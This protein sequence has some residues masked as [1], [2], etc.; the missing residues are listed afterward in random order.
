M[1]WWDFYYTW[2]FCNEQARK[3]YKEGKKK[4]T[5]SATKMSSCVVIMQKSSSHLS[6]CRVCVWALFCDS[7]TMQHCER[8]NVGPA[9]VE[10]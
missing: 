8:D 7:L 4:E 3:Q 6:V 10:A 9:S 2:M 5:T 1:K